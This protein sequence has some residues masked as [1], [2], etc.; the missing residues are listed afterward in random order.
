MTRKWIDCRDFPDETGCRLY[1]SGE[2]GVGRG[3]SDSD[4][5]AGRSI[6]SAGA[7][8][9][10]SLGG[11][12]AVAGD[13]WELG[14][15]GAA[16]GKRGASAPVECASADCETAAAWEA[17]PAAAGRCER[18]HAAG[19]LVCVSGI[20]ADADTLAPR[21]GAEKVELPAPLAGSAAA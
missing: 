15:R 10:G 6:G 19:S 9:L 21:A 12:A 8:L 2:E 1:L 20:A 13:R 14:C 16:G 11:A 3:N 18:A 7:V 5:R 17:E 4:G